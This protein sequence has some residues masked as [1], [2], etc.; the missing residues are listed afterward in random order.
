M[1]AGRAPEACGRR[2]YKGSIE[3]RDRHLDI[4]EGRC[5][6]SVPMQR[7]WRHDE[8]IALADTMRLAA[9]Y[10]LASEFVG[11]CSLGRSSHLQRGRSTHHDNHRRIDLVAA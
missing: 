9:L 4:T 10:Q 8:D 7:V 5:H 3:L 2:N 1:R 11:C 6:V